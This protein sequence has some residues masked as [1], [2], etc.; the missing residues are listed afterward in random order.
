[1]VPT[2]KSSF[3]GPRTRIPT[4][5]VVEDEALLRVAI[6]NYLLECGFAVLEAGDAAEAIETLKADKAEI[7]VVFTDILMP[8][9]MDGF[10]LAQ[11]I[12]DHR[13]GLPVI[14][15]SGDAQ[16]VEVAKHLCA[17]HPFFAKP[18]NVR[19]VSTQIRALIEAKG[20]T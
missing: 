3:P 1:M 8:G 9:E 18:Y 14:L 15:T 13:P 17:G 20:R 7:D 11:W 10:G 2:Y 5:L 19:Q 12:W 4:I 6:S 16:K